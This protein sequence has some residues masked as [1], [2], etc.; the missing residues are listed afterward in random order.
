VQRRMTMPLTSGVPYLGVEIEDVLD[1]A[2][3]TDG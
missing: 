1:L 2:E 3:N